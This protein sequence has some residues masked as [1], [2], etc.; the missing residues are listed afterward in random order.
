MVGSEGTLGVITEVTVKLYP[1]PE[2]CRPPSA[3]FPSMRRRC[4]TTIAI[5]QLGV[6]IARC[7]LMDAKTVRMVNATTSWVCAKSRCC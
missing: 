4:N 2:S 6:P 3:H 5:I 1:L 7:E